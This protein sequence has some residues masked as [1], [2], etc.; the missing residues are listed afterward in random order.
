MSSTN[1]AGRTMSGARVR[2]RR[3]WASEVERL[4][5]GRWAALSAVEP[6]VVEDTVRAMYVA[7][8]ERE[9]D[10]AGLKH[11]ASR[12][13]AGLPL[14]RLMAE[15]ARARDGELVLRAVP[16]QEEAARLITNLL[17]VRLGQPV[18]PHVIDR[19]RQRL[20]G[21]ELWWAIATDEMESVVPLPGE[22]VRRIASELAELKAT[23]AG[24]RNTI[25]ALTRKVATLEDLL[26]GD[27]GAAGKTPAKRNHQ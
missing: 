16:S 4:S 26:A 6:T 10:P 25:S 3:M 18:E 2:L 24:Q 13:A 1:N 20:A 27:G 8:L 9:P 19:I 11:H 14:E 23:V 7:I 15:M 21:G 22:T 17:A 5:A 12:L